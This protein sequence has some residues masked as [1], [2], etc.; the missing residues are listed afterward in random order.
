MRNNR[1]LG[2]AYERIE[3]CALDYA[4][5][6]DWL[7]D[8]GYRRI[9]LL[10][11]SLGATKA[12][13]YAAHDPD[14]RIKAVIALSGPRWSAKSYLA[15]ESAEKFTENLTR[16][17]ETVAAGRPDELLEITFPIGPTM[18]G[19]ANYITKY[20]GETYSI[21]EWADRITIPSFRIDGE[22]ETLITIRG[23]GDELVK[24]AV[25]SPHRGAEIIPG[26]D[27]FY[28]GVMDLATAPVIRWLDQLPRE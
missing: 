13:Y 22:Y 3:D 28:N 16:A 5:A 4:P 19:A 7:N 12:L 21:A 26:A 20:S 27:H 14:P 10:G 11:H 24:Y 23:L 18:F 1:Y 17:Q 25:N 2:S 15:S 6:I 9:A 8:R